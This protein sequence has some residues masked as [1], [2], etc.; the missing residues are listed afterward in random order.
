V[1]DALAHEAPGVLVFDDESP[2]D[3]PLGR[4]MLNFIEAPLVAGTRSA[5]AV[6]IEPLSLAL[7]RDR[8]SPL[9][10]VIVRS[11]TGRLHGSFIGGADWFELATLSTWARRLSSLL[12]RG[13]RRPT[14]RLSEL[15]ARDEQT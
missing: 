11:P 2:C 13:V 5:A 6:G 7:A 4:V 14:L 10:W 8:K 3:S 15:L 9:A 12:E 1:R